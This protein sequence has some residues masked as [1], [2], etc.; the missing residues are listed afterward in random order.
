[1]FKFLG[2]LVA[3]GAMSVA[4]ADDA[5]KG[6]HHG[7]GHHGGGNCGPKKCYMVTKH[8]GHV[9]DKTEMDYDL[10][11]QKLM[12][13]KIKKGY[14]VTCECDEDHGHCGGNH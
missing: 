7:G 9:T 10:C 3:V 4:Y 1:M 2:V 14:S 8:N 6:G 5:A 11:K 12:L 13:I